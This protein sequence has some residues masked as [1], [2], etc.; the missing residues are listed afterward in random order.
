MSIDNDAVEAVRSMPAP[1]SITY[2][3]TAG[4]G[5]S[6]YLQSLLEGRLTGRRCPQCAKVY[7]ARGSCPMCAV[8]LAEPVELHDR[9]TVTSFCIVN[10]PF[11]GQKIPIPYVA[12]NIVVDGADLAFSHLILDCEASE[13]RM[14]LRVEAVW[15]PSSEWGPSLENISHFRPTGE[16]DAPFE[17]YAHHL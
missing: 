10:V 14:G 15:R 9:G 13:V 3:W 8:L 4:P 7:L 11:L 12:A 2:D 17:S 6:T 16:P 5:S 1:I